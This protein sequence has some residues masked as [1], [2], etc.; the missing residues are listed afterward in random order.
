M[1]ERRAWCVAWI[2]RM[3]DPDHPRRMQ[4]CATFRG[5]RHSE[6]ADNVKTACGHFVILPCGGERRV[7]TCL[8]CKERVERR[9]R[10]RGS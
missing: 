1:G 6:D 2:N 7:P 9:R 10:K 3:V 8:D 4:W 5:H